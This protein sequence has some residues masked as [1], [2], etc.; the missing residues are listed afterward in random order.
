MKTDSLLLLLELFD[1]GVPREVHP[2]FRNEIPE[3]FLSIRSPTRNFRNFL[4]E[5]KEPLYSP[6]LIN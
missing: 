4:V 6:C 3:N 1:L 2:K 5:W